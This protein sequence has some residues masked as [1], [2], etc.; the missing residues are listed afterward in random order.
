M[1][2]KVL[3]VDY[4]QFEANLLEAIVS[5]EG[6]DVTSFIQ[7]EKAAELAAQA[8]Q[9]G[10]PYDLIFVEFMLSGTTGIEFCKKMKAIDPTITMVMVTADY[11]TETRLTVARY[12]EFAGFINKA[13][14]ISQVRH[15]LN[16]AMSNKKAKLSGE[17]S[18][19]LKRLK[20]T[21]NKT[22]KTEP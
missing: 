5:E 14:D 15:H 19:Y 13:G 3:I 21:Q 2:L 17:K 12:G 10:N 8:Y 18:E 11:S 16:I 22:G 1:R 9:G 6:H 7:P 4:D 20:D